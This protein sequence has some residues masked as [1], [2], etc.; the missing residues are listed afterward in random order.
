MQEVKRKFYVDVCD[1]VSPKIELFNSPT[2][3]RGYRALEFI[4]AGELLVAS[5]AYIV[6]FVQFGEII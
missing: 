3:G 4:R 2:K 5:K 6:G 1:F